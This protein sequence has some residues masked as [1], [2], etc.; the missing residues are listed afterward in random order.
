MTNEEL[1]ATDEFGKEL[2]ENLSIGN[3]DRIQGVL[4][5]LGVALV[6]ELHLVTVRLDE[7]ETAIRNGELKF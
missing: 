3:P 2:V 1:R 4:I 5:R 6:E 7:I